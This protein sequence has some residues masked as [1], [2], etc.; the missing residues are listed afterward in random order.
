VFNKK[1]DRTFSVRL[2]TLGNSQVGEVDFSD[3][4]SPLLLVFNHTSCDPE[5]E[6]SSLVIG[7][8][9]NLPEWRPFGRNLH[10][11][12]KGFADGSEGPKD[13]AFKTAEIHLWIGAA[14]KIVAQ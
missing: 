4:F 10:E 6:F 2:A 5:A 3:L 9:D 11:D 1:R 14:R 8:C 12:Y 7:Y 13:K